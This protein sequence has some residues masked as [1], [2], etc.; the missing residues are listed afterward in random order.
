MAREVFFEMTRIGSYVKVTAIDSETMVEVSIV[1]T[2]KVSSTAL[3]ATALRKLR[4]VLA[5]RQFKPI[6]C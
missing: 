5:K 3:K 4:Y 1:G 2:P 6:D